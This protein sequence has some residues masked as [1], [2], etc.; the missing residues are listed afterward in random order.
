[1]AITRLQGY[2]GLPMNLNQPNMTED[3]KFKDYTKESL[4]MDS[5]PTN[6]K[7]QCRTHYS[8]EQ[9][10]GQPLLQL[11]NRQWLPNQLH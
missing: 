7:V 10:V 4:Q 1:M 11:Y 2:G 6:W 8:L 3:V 9:K 5:N